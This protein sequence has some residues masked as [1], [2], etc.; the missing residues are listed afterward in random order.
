LALNIQTFLR[1]EEE[2]KKTL[3]VILALV[4]TTSMACQASVD[5]GFAPTATLATIN[6]PSLTP[7]ATATPFQPGTVTLLPTITLPPTA[8]QFPTLTA[9]PVEP[10]FTASVDANCRVGPGTE[11]HAVT[12]VSKG[13][14]YPIR[15]IA[16][17]KGKTWWVIDTV[18]Q[19][20]EY[21]CF[22]SGTVG[23]A[24]GSLWMVPFAPIPA[25]PT[26]DTLSVSIQNDYTVGICS[27]EFRPVDFDATV[28][29]QHLNPGDFDPGSI[30]Y[31]YGI[32][33]G[34]YNVRFDDCGGGNLPGVMDVTIDAGHTE[35]HTP[36]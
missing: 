29:D 8:T 3:I 28:P 1:K 33:P 10:M 27:V 5:L 4:F 20:P 35:F 16:T 24:T 22:I 23:I 7:A 11:W 19:R 6:V 17:F 12:V 14:S 21:E 9:L 2:M 36:N 13:S 30:R 15:A 26:P 25:T 18:G 31:F 34:H 32:A